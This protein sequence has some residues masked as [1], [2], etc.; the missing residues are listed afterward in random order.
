[1]IQSEVFMEGKIRRVVPREG[2]LVRVPKTMARLPKEGTLVDFSGK[3]GKYCRRR[4]ACKD[5]VIQSASI[6]PVSSEDVEASTATEETIVEESS[7]E[8]SESSVETEEPSHA[9]VR[10]GKYR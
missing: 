8:E 7:A 10:R 2:S 3:E 1:M 6:A 9:P 5:V 4:E